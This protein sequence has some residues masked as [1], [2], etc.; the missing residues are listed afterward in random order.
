MSLLD[1]LKQQFPANGFWHFTEPHA[2]IVLLHIHHDCASATVSLYGGQVLS[3]QPRGEDDLLWLSS[4]AHF[5]PGKAIRG[6][7]PIC[8]PWFGPHPSDADAPAHGTVRKSQW[9]LSS[10]QCDQR[11][12][13]IVLSYPGD[14]LDLQ[15]SIGIDSQLQLSLTTNNRGAQT[16]TISAALHSYFAISDITDIT[17]TGLEDKPFR[18]AVNNDRIC[19][20][21]GPI[22]FNGELDRV[23]QNVDQAICIQDPGLKRLIRIDNHGSSSAVVW[24]PWIEK[25]AR[26]GDMGPEGYRQMVCV[27]TANA[28][29]D[30]ISLSPG[31]RHS[32]SAVISVEDL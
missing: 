15:L 8:W 5:Q 12:A 13:R 19:L 32:L 27:E 9:Q 21:R 23:Y 10:L 24:N 1:D 3:F 20:Q 31:Q 4:D 18:D 14:A 28:D 6:G 30:C 2:G 26:L 17:L 7:I 29:S 16:A 22:H 25:S 11:S